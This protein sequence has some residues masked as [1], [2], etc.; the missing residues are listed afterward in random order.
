MKKNLMWIVSLAATG[1]L[2]LLVFRK[3]E[4]EEV[5]S[6][7]SKARPLPLLAALT[8]SFLTNGWL[9]AVK[10]RR[11]LIPLGL[12]ISARESFLVKMGST[13]VKSILPLRSGE[14]SRVIYLKRRY[15]FSAARAA[16][17]IALELFLNIFVFLLLIAA[18]GLACPRTPPDVITAAALVLAAGMAVFLAA[19]RSAP[20][21]WVR[22]LLDRI[23]PPRL[24]G[25]LE[26][27]LTFHRFFSRRQILVPLLHSVV[28]QGGKLLSF[29]L[30]AAAFRLNFPPVVYLV[31]LP[32]SIL[33]STIPVTLLGIGLREGSLIELIPPYSSVA[34]EAVLAP[35]LAFS[36]VEYI[37][38]ALLGLLWT[39]K[40][41]RRILERPGGG[42]E[43]TGG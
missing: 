1:L 4:P 25:G 14:A 15:G 38:P 36:L 23:P 41:T 29:S 33:V 16:G 10:W 5:F 32:F 28:I 34:A 27:L 19:G 42:G 43:K 26:T 17:S 31:I 30:I 11:I 7:L 12:E 24:R 39:G 8:V 35:A 13:P 40:F 22:R 20:R 6:S 3:I 18:G 9:A 21:R 2:L 37:F